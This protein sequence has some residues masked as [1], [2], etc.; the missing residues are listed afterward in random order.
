MNLA[1]KRLLNKSLFIFVLFL[2]AAAIGG[3]SILQL[4]ST[5][6]KGNITAISGN[7]GSTYGIHNISHDSDDSLSGLPSTTVS[8]NLPF[9]KTSNVEE[10]L[11]YVGDW[12]GENDRETVTNLKVTPDAQASAAGAYTYKYY[13]ASSADYQDRTY[14]DTVGQFT[15]LLDTDFAKLDYTS[16]P[17]TSGHRV[18]IINAELDPSSSN[19][20]YNDEPLEAGWDTLV[21]KVDATQPGTT[22]KLSLSIANGGVSKRVNASFSND[23]EMIGLQ[24]FDDRVWSTL[25]TYTSNYGPVMKVAS[26]TYNFVSKESN[27]NRFD[28]VLQGD[29]PKDGNAINALT[30]KFAGQASKDDEAM[31]IWSNETTLRYSNNES[32]V[33]IQYPTNRL[34]Y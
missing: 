23:K 14:L 13:A 11:S 25:N 27:N 30:T 12:L 7:F 10:G 22:Y 32:P 21:S 28:I 3:Y 16:E 8:F 26:V 15:G 4:A 9:D 20:S 34:E 17:T 29:Q 6:A 18:V 24:N 5:A 31:F 1:T 19:S 33:F 2:A